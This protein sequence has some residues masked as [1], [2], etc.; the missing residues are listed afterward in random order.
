[1][2]I[3]IVALACMLPGFFTIHTIDRDEARFALASKQMIETGDY[4]SIREQ[5]RARNKKPVGIHWLQVLSVK[6]TGHGAEAPVWAYR[7]PSLAGAL[8]ACLGTWWI[9][10]GF[11]RPRA[12]L[13]AGLLMSAALLMSV[14]ARLAKTD[15]M[16]LASCVLAL[17]ALVRVWQREQTGLAMPALFWTALAAGILIKGPIAPLLIAF[18]ILVLVIVEGKAAWLGRLKPKWGF[19]WLAL[20]VLP[21]LV[22][23][24]IT[25]RGAFFVEALTQDLFAKVV[26]AQESHGAPPGAYLAAFF[27]TMW[28]AAAF[29]ALSIPFAF[30]NLRRPPILFLLAS[31]VPFWLFMEAMPT[32]LPHYVLPAY[33]A[34]AIIVGIALDEDRIDVRGWVKWFFSLGPF[35]VPATFLWLGPL[36]FFLLEKR[37]PIVGLLVLIAATALGWIAWRWLVT[38]RSAR[39]AAV[40]SVGSAVLLYT[41]LF[42]IIMPEMSMLRISDRLA[43][44]GAAALQC[45]DPQFASAGYQEPSLPFLAGSATPLG[46]G[47]IAANF[48][49]EGGCRLA[50]V[51]SRALP[52]F[53]ERAQDLGFDVEEVDRLRGYAIS[54]GRWVEFGLYVRSEDETPDA[55]R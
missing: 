2:A 43:A 6:A 47:I 22:A 33:P 34:I 38:A 32:K 37:I 44:R 5:D 4:V 46:D 48:L 20:L 35:I 28:P 13:L 8:I 40:A 18:T 41:A 29:A 26:E 53:T 16:L 10:L 36:L 15:A 51:E 24:G 17:G 11:A 30:D 31:A 21:W 39:A 50:F 14:E 42:G 1:M 12:A 45:D 7:L 9:A 49:A 3:L 27:A 55:A 19:A 23:I 54:N 52:S 25:T